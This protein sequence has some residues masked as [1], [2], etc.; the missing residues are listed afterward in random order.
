MGSV[1]I[2]GEHRSDAGRAAATAIATLDQ[3]NGLRHQVFTSIEKGFAQANA[4]R[5]C[6]IEIHGRR[7]RCVRGQG[8]WLAVRAAQ[9]PTATRVGTDEPRTITTAHGFLQITR[10]GHDR[11]RGDNVQCVSRTEKTI[12]R[13]LSILECRRQYKLCQLPPHGRRVQLLI[14]QIDRPV[15]DVFMGIEANF[16]VARDA[17]NHVDF[18]MVRLTTSGVGCIKAVEHFE[19]RIVDGV[20][21]VVGLG[22]GDVGLA[23]LPVELLD[24]IGH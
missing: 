14:G 7:K 16:L 12:E 24:L 19:L 11:H 5:K 3:R 6:I 21:V 2:G 1:F 18:A 15:A 13:L 9:L 10:F 20:S 22:A 4:A 17:P 8:G 23:P